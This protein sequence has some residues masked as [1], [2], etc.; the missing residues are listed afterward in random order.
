MGMGQSHTQRQRHHQYGCQMTS[1]PQW[2]A[3]WLLM[4]YGQVC[5]MKQ[6]PLKYSFS[7]IWTSKKQYCL[8]WAIF[9]Y[10][11]ISKF[12][13]PVIYWWMGSWVVLIHW[14]LYNELG[15]PQPWVYTLL[16]GNLHSIALSIYLGVELMGLMVITCSISHE[17]TK[18]FSSGAISF[19][20]LYKRSQTLESLQILECDDKRQ[21]ENI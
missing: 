12:I 13:Y 9:Y 15:G 14:P 1:E 2:T 5:L 6:H 4:G 10:T 20:L 7:S 21:T 17:V 19:D 11:Y 16:F 18:L 3:L 8:N